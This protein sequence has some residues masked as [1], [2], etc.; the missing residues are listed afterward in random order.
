MNSVKHQG[1]LKAPTGLPTLALLAVTATATLTA[2]TTTLPPRLAA[3]PI[4]SGDVSVYKLP[5]TTEYSSGLN[6]IPVG[7][8]AYLEVQVDATIPVNKI[9]G[10]AWKITLQ[11]SASKAVL[12][13]SP[14]GSAVPIDE[15]SDRLI[16]QIAGRKVLRADAVGQYVV[17]ATV[18][19]NGTTTDIAQTYIAAKYVG[20]AAC[21]VCHSGGLAQPMV[22]TWS[23]TLHSEIFK[24]GING[25]SGT[26]GASCLPCHTVGYDVN[27]TMD[28]GGFT[29]LMKQLN[30]TWPAKLQAGNWDAVPSALQNVANIQCENCHGPGSEHANYGGAL[31][32]ISKPN[33]SGSCNR[34]HNA[35]THHVK[36][37]EWY[38]SMHAVTTRDATGTGREGCVGCHTGTGFIARMQ[39]AT[40]T[41]ASYRSIDCGS[42][43]EP[44]GATTPDGAA[45][46][47][48]NLAKVTLADGTVVSQGGTGLLC[49]NCHQ[50]RQ[51]AATYTASTAGSSHYGAHHGPQADMLQG[52]NAVNYGKKIPSSAHA[53]VVDDT[54]VTC[55]MQATAATD[56]AFLS[57]GGHTFKPSV[58]DA[59][60]NKIELVAACQSCHGPDVTTFNFPLFD[61]NND[62]VID[63]AQ[64]EVQKMMDQLSTLLPPDNKVK[65]ALAID[66][67][68]TNQQLKAAYNWQFVH[69]D[70]SL[71]IHNMAYTVGILKASIA[72]LT[73]K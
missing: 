70:G 18:S 64:T 30:W 44:H 4:S 24:D 10:V 11:P 47:V 41:D 22:K 66:A 49:M 13:D 21:T 12:S 52:V 55:H 73:K 32:A 42:C 68:W 19:A 8:P 34:C 31:M 38:S 33:N 57:A 59:K 63:G 60:G 23:K 65:S 69:D 40:I 20:V 7:E 67:T 26:T 5:S 43:H 56:P 2:Q 29:T 72:D 61:Y 35:P 6:T 28:N 1:I 71:G 27:A 17:T 50:A 39:G 51:N 46:L 53:D 9:T 14:L 15:P 48:R 3:R 37:T 16:Y 58:T 36:S 62:G 25:G 54:C 45:H